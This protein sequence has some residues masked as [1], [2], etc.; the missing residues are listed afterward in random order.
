M[1]EVSM[2]HSG[3]EHCRN[4]MCLPRSSHSAGLWRAVSQEERV[5][6]V[7]SVAGSLD[8][9]CREEEPSQRDQVLLQLKYVHDGVVQLSEHHKVDG[10]AG[11]AVLGGRIAREPGQ[12]VVLLQNEP[13]GESTQV[14]ATGHSGAFTS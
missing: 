13:A 1:R 14:R 8:S 5:G 11:G 12:S 7:Q 3:N 10:K 9:G 6:H 2:H 4:D